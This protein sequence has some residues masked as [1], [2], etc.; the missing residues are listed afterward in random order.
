MSAPAAPPNN[1]FNLFRRV[2]PERFTK[3][4]ITGVGRS[5]TTAVAAVFYSLG[6]HLG[7]APIRHLHEDLAFRQLLRQGDTA[8]LTSAL[9][10][11]STRHAAVAWKDPKIYAAA[12]GRLMHLLPDDWLVIGVLRDPLAVAQ[13]RAYSDGSELLP[14]AHAVARFQMKLLAFLQS[15][16]HTVGLVSYE[17]FMVAP[18]LTLSS[19]LAVLDPPRVPDSLSGLS[20]EVLSQRDIYRRNAVPHIN[21]RAAS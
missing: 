16:R 18:E 4:L 8:A 11:W 12:S 19:L 17:R 6:F 21:E 9:Q 13:R 2:G 7:D 5:G 20:N 3:V 1:G 15:V 14:I 10:A